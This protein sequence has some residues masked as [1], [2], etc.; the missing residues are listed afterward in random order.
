[1][2]IIGFLALAIIAWIGGVMQHIAPCLLAAA[3][4]A[5]VNGV[6]HWSAAR[7]RHV[8]IVTAAALVSDVL[9]TTA[10]VVVTG[11]ILSPFIMIYVVQVI[12][13]AMLVGFVPALVS[14]VLSALSCAAAIW[15]LPATFVGGLVDFALPSVASLHY[16]IAWIGFLLYCLSLL[17]FLGGYIANRLRSSERDLAH[18]HVRMG[19]AL[20][21]LRV[22]H[23]DLAATYTRLRATEAQL[24]H[25]EKMRALG[26]FV[27]GI[28][29]ELNNPI[30][31]VAGNI[32]HLCERLVPLQPVLAAHAAEQ[33]CAPPGANPRQAQRLTLFVEELPGLL[34]DCLEGM[35]R[36]RDIVKSLHAFAR[37]GAA[38]PFQPS[39]LHAILD[40]TLTLVRH[41]A[42]K[43]VVIERSYGDIPPVECLP[44]Q[45]DQVFFNVLLNAADAVSGGG[46]I[47]VS[48][49]TVVRSQPGEPHVAIS[50]RDTGAGISAEML[51]QIFEPF[52]TT[53]PIGKGAGLGLSVSYGIVSRHGGTITVTSPP[54]EGA[55]FTIVLPV[56]QPAPTDAPRNPSASFLDASPVVRP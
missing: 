20:S 7:L 40:R 44:S 45:L 21:A 4:A 27:A 22:A 18:S 51:T 11:G 56:A 53:K 55:T 37:T 19:R 8:A 41:R 13:T 47:C 52:F 2:V 17:A 49:S 42:G 9:L 50:I 48:T 43:S 12:A 46:T 29:H 35:R 26:L 1:M 30:A 39:D 32:D 31:V 23:A 16:Q 25:D 3:A 54:G 14:A 36:A 10:L 15:L 28:A 33:V 5:I 34:S 24:V 38:D 6:N